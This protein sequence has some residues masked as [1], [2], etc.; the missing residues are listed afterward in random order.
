MSGSPYTEIIN[1]ILGGLLVHLNSEIGPDIRDAGFDPYQKLAS[2]SQGIG[3]GTANYS[4]TDLTGV[5]SVRFM[6]MVASNVTPS[7]NNLNGQLNFHAVLNSSLA[8]TVSGD[9][10]VLFVDPGISGNLRIDG[11]TLAGSGNVQGALSDNKLC[12]NS[13]TGLSTQ[14]GYASAN[15]WINDLGPVNDLLGPLENLV[16]DA[17]KVAIECLI[18]SQINSLVSVQVNKL[19]PLCAPAT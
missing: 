5:S 9:L 15:I 11:C 6:D 3:M 18:S 17:A 14:F 7:G 13:I 10:R 16:L 4:V 19:L 2:G 12:V 1:E 8:A